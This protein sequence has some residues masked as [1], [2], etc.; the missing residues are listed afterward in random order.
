MQWE[1]AFWGLPLILP[2]HAKRHKSSNFWTRLRLM[3][4]QVWSN[5]EPSLI[6]QGQIF[7]LMHDVK[8]FQLPPKKRLQR[9]KKTNLFSSLIQQMQKNGNGE[10]EFWRQ[11]RRGKNATQR[12]FSS[13]LKSL[14]IR[15]NLKIWQQKKM[16]Q[17]NMERIFWGSKKNLAK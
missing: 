16:G 6:L 1:G 10:W 7:K 11:M 17:T 9:K 5:K 3:E 2:T 13:S 8:L 15:P 14:G 12:F 4:N